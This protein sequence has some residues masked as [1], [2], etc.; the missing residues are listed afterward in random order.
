MWYIMNRV[1]LT[2][3]EMPWFLLHFFLCPCLSVAMPY[4]RILLCIVFS[5]VHFSCFERKHSIQFL[6]DVLFSM[7]F[8][9]LLL[10]FLFTLSN[11]VQCFLAQLVFGFIGGIKTTTSSKNE[12][13]DECTHLFL[14]LQVSHWVCAQRKQRSH[15]S[16]NRKER[17][18]NNWIEKLAMVVVILVCVSFRY[19]LCV[20]VCDCYNW[21]ALHLKWT[22]FQHQFNSALQKLLIW[23]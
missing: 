14:L 13:S 3:F 1:S 19:C 11:L 20:Y 15:W 10:L 4:M 16:E 23:N 22:F 9:L 17:H 12:I 8:F 6:Y 5:A 7:R 2:V 21:Y 18:N